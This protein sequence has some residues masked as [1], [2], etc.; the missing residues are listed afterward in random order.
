MA[1]NEWTDAEVHHH[2]WKKSF[3]KMSRCIECA[4][5]NIR[6]NPKHTQLGMALCKETVA[7]FVS[8]KRNV[9]CKSFEVVSDD[10]ISM[11]EDYLKKKAID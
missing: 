6:D 3:C 1:N 10:V 4:K 7:S 9:A 8:V 11:R 2:S 5:F